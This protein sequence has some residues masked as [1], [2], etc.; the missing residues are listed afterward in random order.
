MPRLKLLES[1]DASPISIHDEGHDYSNSNEFQPSNIGIKYDSSKQAFIFS[2]YSLSIPFIAFVESFN[3]IS[4][5]LD[6]YF[7]IHSILG[8]LVFLCNNK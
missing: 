7:N 5:T 1:K 6:L 8:M 2:I 4:N 3:S